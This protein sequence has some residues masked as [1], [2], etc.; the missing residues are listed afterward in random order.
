[1]KKHILKTFL[2][3]TIC[4]ANVTNITFASDLIYKENIETKVI[5]EGLVYK[6]IERITNK[7][8]IDIYVLEYDLNNENI[9][10]EILRNNEQWSKRT[11]L[12]TMATSNTLAGVN[13]SFFDTS[14]TYSDILGFEME[15]GLP[16]YAK[17]EYNRTQANSSS[18]NQKK[19]GTIS[20]GY[21]SNQISFETED[22]TTIYVDSVNGMQDFENPTVF[23]GNVIKDTSYIDQNYDL[24]KVIIEN[25]KVMQIIPPKT[26]ATL[27]QN[28]I[29]LITKHDYVVERMPVGTGIKYNLQTNLGESIHDYELMLSGGGN[30]LNNGEIVNDGIQVYPLLRVPRTAVGTTEDNKLIAAVI[31]GRGSSI[32]ATRSEVAE[33]MLQLGAT[34]AIN[35]DGGGSSQ[36][37]AINHNNV[38]VVQNVPSDGKERNI[39]NGLGFVSTVTDRNLSRIELEVNYENA[40]VG[41]SVNLSLVGYDEYNRTIYLDDTSGIYNVTGIEAEIN[42]NKVTPLTAG[43]GLIEVSYGN[44]NASTPINVVNT[45]K[46][47]VIQ[48][49]DKINTNGNAKISGA[50]TSFENNTMPFTMNMQNIKLLNTNM[51]YIKDDTFYS[52]GEEGIANIEINYAGVSKIINI[53]VVNPFKSDDYEYMTSDSYSVSDNKYIIN[54]TARELDLKEIIM[55]GR[56]EIKDNEVFDGVVNEINTLAND[57]TLRIFSGGIETPKGMTLERSELYRNKFSNKVYEDINTNIINLQYFTSNASNINQLFNLESQLKNNSMNNVIIQHSALNY[58]HLSNA[59]FNVL[60]RE[61]VNE[62]ANETGVNV[63][64]VNGN[65]DRKNI[66]VE[67]V[68]SVTYIEI[69]KV[70]ISAE[71]IKTLSNDMYFYLD[72][73][74]V[75]KY[76]F[77]N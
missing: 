7:G 60:F 37:I 77:K 42:G 70:T 44:F 50:V 17:N 15:D 51:G 5:M 46:D 18:L 69:P 52:T 49:Q 2:T 6:Q 39:S 8:F 20:F 64:V 19:D 12:T 34:N 40:F 33:I 67:N 31:D 10:L 24:Y 22:G 74:G 58:D 48:F 65:A 30:L 54:E 38:N 71:S 66:S 61:M 45:A 57:S 55:L 36:M 27:N 29:A 72:N 3:M 47:L 76:S 4:L 32:G 68:D 16:V 62:Y 63:Y 25:D 14:S 56:V 13:G 73:D 1:M 53:E 75:L 26:V 28:Q 9:E 43:I 21:V 23:T 41:N 11:P 35:L 59:R